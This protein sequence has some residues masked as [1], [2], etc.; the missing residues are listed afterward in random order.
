MISVALEAVLAALPHERLDFDPPQTGSCYVPSADLPDLSELPVDEAFLR[1]EAELLARG[2]PAGRD[3]AEVD[4]STFARREA[5]A[6]PFA[7]PYLPGRWRAAR[8][9]SERS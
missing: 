6:V 1:L 4:A 3:Q 9:P 7:L 5:G 8:W 2:V